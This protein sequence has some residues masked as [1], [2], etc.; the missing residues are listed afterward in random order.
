MFRKSI[1]ALLALMLLA[2]ALPALAEAYALV[3]ILSDTALQR[4]RLQVSPLPKRYRLRELSRLHR[5]QHVRVSRRQRK[6]LR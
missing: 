5:S 4:D 1:C 3:P 2:P 6:S